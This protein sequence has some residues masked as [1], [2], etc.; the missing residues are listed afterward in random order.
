M[1][2]GPTE[3]SNLALLCWH[4][5]HLVHE[6]G[7]RIEREAGGR[8]APVQDERIVPL[9]RGEVLDLAACVDVVLIRRGAAERSAPARATVRSGHGSRC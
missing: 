5:H 1:R 7:W 9:W 2:G 3:L 4:H 8:P 6:G